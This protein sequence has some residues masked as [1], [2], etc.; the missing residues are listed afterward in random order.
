MSENRVI[1]IIAGPN[2]AGK[3]TFARR[4][5]PEGE[6]IKWFVNADLIALG[7]SPFSPESEAFEAGRLMLRQIDKLVGQGE[8]FSLETTLSGLGYARAIPLWRSVGYKIRLNFL[9]LPDEDWAV[10]RVAARV[11]Q[12]GHSV[13]E[14]V[15]R[16][17]F[18]AGLR[19]FHL[20]YKQLA[21][22][23]GLYDNSG[24]EPVLIDRGGSNGVA[25]EHT[26]RGA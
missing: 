15:I 18:S 19:N 7:L 4:F 12:G 2:G 23:W 6:G 20:V 26:V 8:S 24:K 9:S 22:G 10:A 17:R 13:P 14:E 21:D 1:Y 25:P 3:T 16:R 11:G 5:I